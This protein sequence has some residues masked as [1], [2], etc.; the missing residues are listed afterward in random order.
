MGATLL[1]YQGTTPCALGIDFLRR[2][3]AEIDRLKKLPESQISEA[4]QQRRR[5]LEKDIY[6]IALDVDNSQNY[7][8]NMLLKTSIHQWGAGHFHHCAMPGEHFLQS[9]YRG[10]HRGKYENFNPKGVRALQTGINA[11][12]GT[13]CNGYIAFATN[14]EAI[15]QK[16]RST[17]KQILMTRSTLSTTQDEW[18]RV[19]IVS[20][21]LGGFASGSF[22]ALKQLVQTIAEE[23][24]IP[25]NFFCILLIPGGT[26]S[27]KDRTNSLAGTAA[28]F[29]ELAAIAT[30][31][32][33]HRQ[34]QPGETHLQSTLSKHIPTLLISDT[35]G[36]D[37]PQGLILADQLS[38]ISETIL[39]L[40]S[41]PLG[42]R[43]DSQ[44]AD[45]LTKANAQTSLTGEPKLGISAGQS[46]IYLGRDRL[47]AYAVPQLCG[48]ITKQL[49]ATVEETAIGQWVGE[50]VT[51]QRLL[52]GQ[53][54]N[55]L[56]S[57]LLD[58]APEDEHSLT[59]PRVM[60][61]IDSYTQT[62][63]DLDLLLKGESLAQLAFQQ[64]IQPAIEVDEVLEMR[65]K[66]LMIRVQQDLQQRVIDILQTSGLRAA[67]QFLSHLLLALEQMLTEA[68]EKQL[69][70]EES[71]NQHLTYVGQ[72]QTKTIPTLRELLHQ[73]SPW[74]KTLFA[75]KR[76]KAR[77]EA[78]IKEAGW[79]Y[80][81]GLK[82]Y[83]RI[84]LQYRAQIA[85]VKTLRMLQALVQER[86][87]QTQQAEETVAT[88][89]KEFRQE[90]V[91]VKNY[92]PRFECSNGFCLIETAEDLKAYYDRLLPDADQA[93]AAKN[94]MIALG[95]DVDPLRLLADANRLEEL[96]LHQAQALLEPRLSALHVVS[97]LRQRFPQEEHLGQILR[98]CD[99]R[100]HEFIQLKD[101]C[102]AEHG[103]HLIQLLGI[104]QTQASDLPDLLRR[105][106][107]ERGSGFELI[108]THDPEKII[109]FQ[110]RANFPLSDWAYHPHA[111]DAYRTIFEQTRFE[112]LHVRVGERYL[113]TPG[114]TLSLLEAQIILVK[115][116]LLDQVKPNGHKFQ[117]EFVGLPDVPL[118]QLH[119]A[120]CDRQGYLRSVSIVS[121]FNNLFLKQGSAFLIE[122]ITYLENVKNGQISALCSTDQAIA[123][124]L[125]PD[126]LQQLQLQIN[127]W[128]QNSIPEAMEWQ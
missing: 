24:Q 20:S 57:R 79:R 29:Q 116:W 111:L 88:L 30:G 45:F 107:Y 23:M 54:K 28:V 4:L 126:A 32:H 43:R 99:R 109:F 115:A 84:L 86:L 61:L 104:D 34:K 103:I 1:I 97:E 56:P 124:L 110:E 65:H 44:A 120:L 59:L 2:R 82:Q 55:Q 39:S 25:L 67:R 66:I 89:L 123:D 8:G 21:S 15:E 108:N 68:S 90:V 10:H 49:L 128:K 41:T 71:L 6:T 73:P 40:V 63:T 125:N 13:R 3:D 48:A 37:S 106:Q 7:P 85:A 70:Y 105:Y 114:Q 112:K 77:I 101:S 76:E 81:N 72:F 93:T 121:R 12:G 95:L 102:E 87:G 69:Q 17:L 98:Q 119:P 5:T 16:I 74:H 38:M 96:L 117:I 51:Q 9:I 35:N 83:Y 11:S 78:Q 100:S 42:N 33:S 60:G 53:R 122:R 46:T 118:E 113:P 47:R 50:F 58:A 91:Q 18:T 26:N 127:W 94:L 22:E 52:A 31:E 14:E 64:A 62:V 36:A 80:I 75:N 92:S 27:G 19:I